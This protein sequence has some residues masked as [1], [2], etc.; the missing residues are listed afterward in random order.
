MKP[1]SLMAQTNG[2]KHMSLLEDISVENQRRRHALTSVEAR[3]L[4][5]P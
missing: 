2:H 4:Y 3:T 1:M 5:E